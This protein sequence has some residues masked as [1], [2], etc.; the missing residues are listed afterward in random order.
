MPA[1]KS[2]P[3]PPVAEACR[4]AMVAAMRPYADQLGPAGMLAVAAALVGQLVAMQDQRT[5]NPAMAMEIV[6]RN[7]ELANQEVMTALHDVPP[8][9]R[10]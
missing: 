8:D 5:M 6:I 10:A 2:R 7:I 4:Q 3:V 9:G 1:I